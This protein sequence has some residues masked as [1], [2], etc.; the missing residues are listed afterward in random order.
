ML[1]SPSFVPRS[2]H[3]AERDWVSVALLPEHSHELRSKDIVYSAQLSEVSALES[4]G[5][6]K[7]M[8]PRPNIRSQIMVPQGDQEKQNIAN[9]DDHLDLQCRFGDARYPY[10]VIKTAFESLDDNYVYDLL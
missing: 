8:M 4:Y 5:H 6:H 9:F 10:Y 2:V 7:R 1:I 3:L